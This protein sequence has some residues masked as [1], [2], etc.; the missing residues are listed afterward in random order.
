MN[1]HDSE[2]IKAI[3]E[4]MSF[5]EAESMDRAD[6]ILLNTCAIR[7]MRIIKYLDDRPT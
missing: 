3:L 4:D 6:L 5:K 2:N 1:V 7:K